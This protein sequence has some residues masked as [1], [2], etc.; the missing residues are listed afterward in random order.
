MS[1]RQ[2][3]LNVNVHTSGAHPAAWRAPGGNPAAF[4]DV[5]YY[6][7]IARISE[8]GL[9]D[10]V[11]LADSLNAAPDP[12]GG[13]SWALDPV[14]IVA[15]MAAVTTKVGFIATASTTFSHPYNVARAFSSLDH[16][17]K[18]RVGWNVVTTYDQRAAGNFG[19][20]GL[21][22]HEDRYARAAEF[23]DVVLA[24]WESWEDGA[25]L[26]ERDTGRFADAK[27]IHRLDHVGKF[28]S[29]AGPLQ[30]PR[31]PQGRPLL[32]QAGSSEQGRDLAARF[33]EAV[34]SVQQVV[35]E[36]RAYYADL[37][38]RAR[39]LNRDPSTL[40]V[41]PGLSLTMGGT[42]AEAQARKRELD[43]IGEDGALQRFAN[44]L[45]VDV[46]ELHLDK[47]V[48]ETL[49]ARIDAAKGSRGFID[50]TIAVVR[51]GSLTVREIIARGGGGHRLLT[52][53]PEQIADFMQEWFTTGAADGFNIMCDVFPE[54]LVAFV[55]Q[56]V[57]LLQRRGLFRTAYEE[58]TLRARYGLSW[59]TTRARHERVAS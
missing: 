27:R 6:Q 11:F 54:G 14:V 34:F 3:H 39:R 30:L 36:A 33:A 46:T 13:P 43:A 37:K 12:T 56:V 9:L 24:L 53:T 16:A 22:E 45:G 10:A 1:A 15:S 25:F 51:D 47:P 57:P 7:E 29:V 58:E 55:D 20:R 28:F 40:A 38:D 18:G 59:P 2:M 32:V 8:R 31:T 41:L 49:I 23:V 48:P 19:L 35:E 52:G 44:R 21:P 50:A 42:E 17:S 4:I 26:G 5:G